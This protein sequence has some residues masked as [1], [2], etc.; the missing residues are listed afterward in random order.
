[1]E[2]KYDTM[3]ADISRRGKENEHGR[4]EKECV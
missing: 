2:E 4:K 3:S 1:M